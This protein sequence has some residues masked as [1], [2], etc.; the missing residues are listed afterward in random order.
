MRTWI[1]VV[2]VWTVVGVLQCGT[3]GAQVVINEIMADPASDWSTTDGDSEYG[4]VND[5]WVEILNAGATPVDMTGWRLR[6]A[7]S[8]SS[9]RYGFSGVIQPGCFFIVYGNEAY[10]W[11]D[12][13]GYPRYGLSLNNSGDTIALVASDL[14]TVIDQ[15][16]YESFQVLDDRSFGRFPD[17]TCYWAVFDALNPLN[18][19]ETD[20]APTPGAP[21]VGSPAEPAN[22]GAIKA[23]YR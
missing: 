17:G 7:V 23:L 12:A 19:P 18:P 9:W 4:S 15:V 20:M 13:N 16:A 8:D 14:A 11:E 10:A 6:D 1:S 3:A 21:N 2:V 5:E 22:W